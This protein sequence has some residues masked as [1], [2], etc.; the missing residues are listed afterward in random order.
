MTD[1]NCTHAENESPAPSP[2]RG[3]AREAMNGHSSSSLS[4]APIFGVAHTR[5]GVA[6]HI[7][8]LA[9]WFRGIV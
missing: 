3:R 5:F 1:N 6:N 9:S 7:P 4:Y 2:A 8:P